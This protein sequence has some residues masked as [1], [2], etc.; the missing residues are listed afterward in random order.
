MDPSLNKSISYDDTQYVCV[1]CVLHE[2]VAGEEAEGVR[3]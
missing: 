2:I 1:L 3:W